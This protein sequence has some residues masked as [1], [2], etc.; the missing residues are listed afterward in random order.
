MVRPETFEPKSSPIGERTCNLAF[1]GSLT[2]SKGLDDAIDAVAA[3]RGRGRSIN[4]S[5]IGF[6]D[7][8]AYSRLTREKGVAD[9]VRLE[10]RQPHRRVLELMRSADL[11]LVP[12]HHDYPEGLPMVL[13]ES[14]A[15]R[16]PLIC[17]D[18]PM[19]V[20]RISKEAA[21]MVPEKRPSAIAEAIERVLDDPDLYHRMSVATLDA[22]NRI[23]CPVQWG[24]LIERLLHAKREDERW[25]ADHAMT[26]IENTLC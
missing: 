25:L 10:G 7:L 5:V 20:G 26:S 6:G 15:T 2:Q 13:Y 9:I 8:E 16:T 22:W 12:S 11:V 23:Q 24:E 19:F 14:L 4:L 1:V 17:S 3:L 18:H 21:M